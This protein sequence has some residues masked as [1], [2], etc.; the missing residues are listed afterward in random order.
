M[1][2]KNMRARN[3][4]KVD[5]GMRSKA[6]MKQAIKQSKQVSMDETASIKAANVCVRGHDCCSFVTRIRWVVVA[7]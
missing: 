1:C 7:H 3:E 6:L 5:M 2:F 4:N